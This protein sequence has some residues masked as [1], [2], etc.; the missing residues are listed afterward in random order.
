MDENVVP[1]SFHINTAWFFN[2]AEAVEN[3]PH[4]HDE[5]AEII[6]FI[7]SDPNN[8]GNPGA[9]VE[10]VLGN[11]RRVDRPIFHFTAVP[12]KRYTKEDSAWTG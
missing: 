5:D 1:G 8:P 12:G 9:G 10:I 2:P 7:G 6:G 11:L 4:T 3:V